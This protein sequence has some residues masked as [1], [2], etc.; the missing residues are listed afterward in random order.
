MIVSPTE[1]FGHILDLI[2]PAIRIQVPIELCLIEAD[3]ASFVYIVKNAQKRWLERNLFTENMHTPL[4]SAFKLC[5]G[6]NSPMFKYI[7]KIMNEDINIEADKNE[8]RNRINVR[9]TTKFNQYK[10]M[11]PLLVQSKFYGTYINDNL[12]INVSRFML[13][14]HNLR[15]ETGRWSRIER[16]N[17]LCDCSNS[18]IQDEY[19]VLF[20]CEKTACVTAPIRLKCTNL[21]EA[22]YGEMVP[23]EVVAKIISDILD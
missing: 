4:A 13:S 16:K 2:C 11:N 6:A 20:E 7:K 15:I 12:R 1:R 22:I 21:Y 9:T 19:H 18:G 14:S 8:I 3:M 10:A 23:I 5:E 17:R